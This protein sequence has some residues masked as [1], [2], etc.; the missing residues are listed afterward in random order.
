MNGHLSKMVD[1]F[2]AVFCEQAA[3]SGHVSLYQREVWISSFISSCHVETVVLLS[4]KKVDGHINID[5]DVEKLHSKG[6]TA[7]YA[8]IKA[9]VEE[10]YGFKISS[11]Y[12][13]QIKD[14]VGIKERKNYN[15]GSGNGRVPTCPREKEEA[16]MDAFQHFN[17]I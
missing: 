8:E 17:L 15:T 10:K 12:I 11:L 16:I 6:G 13:G 1:M 7:T 4:D 3:V 9:Y 14:K 5:L 2:L